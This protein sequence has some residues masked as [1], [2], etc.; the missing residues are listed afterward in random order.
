MAE[1]FGFD[2]R[3]GK[4]RQVQGNERAR[5]AFH[6]SAPFGIKGDET[7]TSDGGRGRPLAAAGLSQN[8]GGKVFHA[9]PQVAVI[10]GQIVGENVVP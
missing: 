9:V 1:K 5:K 2:Q 7:R 8:Q 4:L 6:E 3:F 10:Q